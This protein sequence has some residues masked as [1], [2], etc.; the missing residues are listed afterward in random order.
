MATGHGGWPARL[1]APGYPSPRT[2]S[3]QWQGEGAP[4][5]IRQGLPEALG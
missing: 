1:T 5:R 2:W 3:P 4:R